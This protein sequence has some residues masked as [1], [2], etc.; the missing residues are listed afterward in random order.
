M[1]YRLPKEITNLLQ[2]QGLPWRLEHGSRHIKIIV[3]G[4]FVG[5]LS[6]SPGRQNSPGAGLAN[7]KA[8]IKRAFRGGG[9]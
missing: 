3:N 9:P 7:L 4:R 6:R 2:E 8:Q 1:S 5:I